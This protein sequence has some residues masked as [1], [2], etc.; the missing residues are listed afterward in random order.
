MQHPLKSLRSLSATL[1]T[2]GSL[3][4]GANAAV[5]QVDFDGGADSLFTQ[6]D[7][8]ITAITTTPNTFGTLGYFTQNL[9]CIGNA[10]GDTSGMPTT[11]GIFNTD[12]AGNFSSAQTLSLGAVV[13]DA[14]GT[15][16]WG[17]IAGTASFPGLASGDHFIGFETSTGHFGYMNITL[18]DDGTDSVAT[19][20]IAINYA[21][22]ET[23]SGQSITV[24]AI[25][26]PSSAL[27]MGLAVLG[28]VARR[29]R[30]Y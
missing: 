23:N 13:S 8:D 30:A 24:S 20:S 2:F 12:A 10:D 29:K 16:G 1:I 28:M 3:T 5:I 7:G 17:I 11:Y 25:P 9:L 15:T 21:F 4:G 22:V 18:A 26:E 14:L 6:S 27:L 19:D